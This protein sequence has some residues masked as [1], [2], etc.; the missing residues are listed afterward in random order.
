MPRTLALIAGAALLL[1]TGCGQNSSQRPAVAGY[2][3][4]VNRIEA[5][6]ATPLANIT[7]LGS[8]FAQAQGIGGGSLSG[9]VEQSTMAHALRQIAARRQ[10]LAILR[11]PAPAAQLRALLLQVI[12]AQVRMAR[13]LQKLVVF[14][15]HFNAALQPLDGAMKRLEGVLSQQSAYGAAAVAAV[16]AEKAGALRSFQSSLGA[17]LAK[18]RRLQPPAV[19]KPDYDAQVHALTGMSSNAGKLAD[20]LAHGPQENLQPSLT[21]FDQAAASAQ[22]ATV[23]KAHR[24]A[25]RSYDRQLARINQLSQDVERERMRLANT[26]Q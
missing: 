2:I 1:A 9:F 3:S 14:L 22:S 24:A 15:P 12:D 6:I 8:Q 16:Y 4:R 25:V 26:L 23:Q 19:S 11:T 5:Q 10:Q 7:A 17:I 20:A 13:Q 21:A 18:L